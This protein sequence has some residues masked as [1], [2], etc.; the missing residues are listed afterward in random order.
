M[1]K[2]GVVEGIHLA[3]HLAKTIP[4][5]GNTIAAC[6]EAVVHIIRVKDVRVSPSMFR[7]SVLTYI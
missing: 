7:M 5:V 4:L 6:L 1:L 3:V 2:P